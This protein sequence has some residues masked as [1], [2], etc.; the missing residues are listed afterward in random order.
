M[1]LFEKL[2]KNLNI[3]WIMNSVTSFTLN[4]GS[5]REKIY[6]YPPPP[7]KIG[8][9]T[10]LFVI[11]ITTSFNAYSKLVEI[12]YLWIMTLFEQL[13]KNL[14]IEWILNYEDTCSNKYFTIFGLGWVYREWQIL[15]LLMCAIA[16]FH[17]FSS[18]I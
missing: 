11:L 12:Y 3:E 5:R 8:G 2:S 14:N 13:S 15:Y 10:S 4:N 9:A 6:L 18:S 7:K 1:T 17:S 16:L